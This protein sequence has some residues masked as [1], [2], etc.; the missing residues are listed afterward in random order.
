MLARVRKTTD[1]HLITLESLTNKCRQICPGSIP[2]LKGENETNYLFYLK[3][4]QK[5][6]AREKNLLNLKIKHKPTGS[7][8]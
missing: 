6:K 8:V 1:V 4:K 7:K 3:V 5:K 2:L